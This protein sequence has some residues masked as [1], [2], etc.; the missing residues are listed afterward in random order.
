MILDYPVNYCQPSTHGEID[1]QKL[2]KEAAVMG[3]NEW[4]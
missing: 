1:L 3:E 4:N 2:Y